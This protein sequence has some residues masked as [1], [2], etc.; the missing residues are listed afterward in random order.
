M[1]APGRRVRRPA[2]ER[3]YAAFCAALEKV[4]LPRAPHEGPIDYLARVSAARPD[5]AAEA[6]HITECYT[7]IR[8][9]GESDPD[10]ARELGRRAARFAA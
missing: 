6:A 8:Y 4:G 1:S 2:A 7:R 3:H 10:T 5:L 9:A